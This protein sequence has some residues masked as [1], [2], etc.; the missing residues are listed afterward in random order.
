LATD[1]NFTDIVCTR[2]TTNTQ[3]GT[4][5]QMNIKEDGNTYYWRVRTRRANAR[6]RWSDTRRVVL[7]P[8]GGSGIDSN[9][10]ASGSLKAWLLDG[11][12]VVEADRPS[13]A[14]IRIYNLAGQ[15]QGIVKHSLV[16]GKN[17]IPIE[18]RGVA[19][20]QIRT[21]REEVVIKTV[22]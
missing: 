4:S 22:N 6:D 2:E 10:S 13:D 17:T 20:I 12:L 11:H 1:P 9:T 8:S 14:V 16:A 18:S 15:V 21:D 3:F 7:S 19:I 5:S